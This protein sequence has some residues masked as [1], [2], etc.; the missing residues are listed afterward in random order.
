MKRHCLSL[1]ASLLGLAALLSIDLPSPAQDAPAAPAEQA[2]V[3][4]QARG[5]VH[6]AFAEPTTARPEPSPVVA[7]QPPDPIEEVPPDQKPEG[8]NV[9]W[10]P[11][12]WGFDPDQNDFL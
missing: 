12:Y 8:D 9:Q 1:V 5:P 2:G 3:D 11:G 7:K 10:L 6:E 4:V